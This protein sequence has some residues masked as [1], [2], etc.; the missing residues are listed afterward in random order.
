MELLS[1]AP[2]SPSGASASWCAQ[3]A[4][5][6]ALRPCGCKRAWRSCSSQVQEGLGWHLPCH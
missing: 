5:P 4:V 2:T 3:R 1:G 6:E